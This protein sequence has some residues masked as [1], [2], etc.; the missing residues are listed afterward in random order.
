[1]PF[2][3]LDEFDD[4]GD[5]NEP[6][7]LEEV[8]AKMSGGAVVETFGSWAPEPYVREAPKIGRNEPC[9]CGSKRKFKKCHG[10]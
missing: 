6:I 1:M 9:F 4:E 3:N 2:D 7:S 10:A 8:A 5:P